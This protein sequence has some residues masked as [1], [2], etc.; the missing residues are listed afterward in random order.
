MKPLAT[1]GIALFAVA[2]GIAQAKDDNREFAELLGYKQ[3]TVKKI[4]ADSIR[5]AHK[6]GFARIPIEKL[7]PAAMKQLGIDPKAAAVAKADAEKRKA[8]AAQK[9]REKAA[10]RERLKKKFE[11]AHIVLDYERQLIDA[12]TLVLSGKVELA[13]NKLTERIGAMECWAKVELQRKDGR[14][15]EV[16]HTQLPNLTSLANGGGV[17]KKPQ[18]FKLTI[19]TSQKVSDK[20]K[21]RISLNNLRNADRGKQLIYV[22]GEELRTIKG[23]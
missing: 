20:T 5:I 1:L 11:L 9:A 22:T 18:A 19:Q 7:P 2:F 6:S 17:G 13:K 15:I 3:V 21:L 23:R 4:E 14:W 10:E 8:E 12:N 16:K